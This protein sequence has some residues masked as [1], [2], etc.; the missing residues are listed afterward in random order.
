MRRQG[1]PYLRLVR[2]SNVLA[3]CLGADV[4]CDP[5]SR[6]GVQGTVN[7]IKEVQRRR[8]GG[9][10]GK[11]ERQ[12]GQ[13]LLAPA[14]C[15]KGPPAAVVRPATTGMISEATDYLPAN[16]IH[17]ILCDHVKRQGNSPFRGIS[18]TSFVYRWLALLSTAGTCMTV[19]DMLL[20]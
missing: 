17:S 12:R 16:L 2:D 19:S 5:C 14:Q 7:V 8:V 13:R 3:L 18:V 4:V 1:Q 6:A 20:A 10:Q 9:L 11:G 15:W